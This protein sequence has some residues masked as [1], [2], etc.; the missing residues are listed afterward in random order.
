MVKK[1]FYVV[2]ITAA[3]VGIVALIWWFFNRDTTPAQTGS[4][5]F[6]SG[7]DAPQSGNAV[8]GTPT[9]VALPIE[10]QNVGQGG[11][12]SS[13]SIPAGT[14]TVRT[15]TLARGSYTLAPAESFGTYTV[16]SV[17]GG[18]L[19]AGQYTFAAPNLTTT[20]GVML[21][22]MGTSSN[23]YTITPGQI[24]SNIVDGIVGTS[25]N[26][27]NI[28]VPGVTWLSGTTT[29]NGTTGNN[30]GTVF[31]PTG[32]NQLNNDT[33]SGGVL[34]NISGGGGGTG[35]QGGLGLG[36][37]LVGAAVAG[38]LSCG[39]AEALA[40]AGKALGIT[41]ST[42]LGAPG[43]ALTVG[44][45]GIELGLTPI[46]VSTVNNG[47]TTV[48]T[49]TNA[50]LGAILIKLGGAH[51]EQ[52]V[53]NTINTF[54]SCLARTV[55][56]IALNQIT[57]SVV[58]WINSGFGADGGPGSGGPSFVTNPERFFTNLAD[59]TAGEFIKGSSLSFLCSPFQ[60]QIRI[61]IA[62]SYAQRNAYSC[63][64]TGVTNNI[65]NFMN[66]SFSAG[67]WPAMLS[68]TTMPTNNPYGAFMYAEA[69]LSYSVQTAQGEQRRQLDLGRGLF[70]F[71]QKKGC[72]N[73]PIR[74]DAS[75]NRSVTEIGDP[76]GGTS[77]EVCEIVN[78]TPGSVIAD[79]IGATESST[80]DQLS[81]AKSFDEIISALIAQLMTRTLQGGLLNLSGQDGYASNFYS[82]EE[83]AA[84]REAQDFLGE[85]QTD[86]NTAQNLGVI[87]QGSIQDI[88]STQRRLSELG[89]CWLGAN[90]AGAAENAAA[91]SSTVAMLET[92]VA[93]YNDQIVRINET[94]TALV[95]FQSRTLSAGSLSDLE[96]VRR[97]HSAAAAQGRLVSSADITTAQQDRATL[98]SQMAT[99]NQQ[100][101]A[102]LTQCNAFR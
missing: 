57:N 25:T 71:K 26:T 63:T 70:E 18:R 29:N 1:I 15:G 34:P 47:Q 87:K 95:E 78:A 76:E 64:L 17:N 101:T 30:A 49:G 69:G 61:A 37:A 102:G 96:A 100:T 89:N 81:L 50:L 2:L 21:S 44:G 38:G 86:S 62:K 51:G 22:P 48:L 24:R 7:Q 72:I 32:I 58:N 88:Q 43:V 31:N 16:T 73:T 82:T 59:K 97:D 74:E 28:G 67:G 3:V 40:W 36:G 4:G 27:G 10:G 19:E 75:A 41:E 68:F 99:I 52:K 90:V 42:T 5:T 45:E 94:I 12:G 23:V 66:G 6:G 91:A 39:A 93:F 54:W 14:Y 56:R 92:R 60:L 83:L 13:Q 33:P 80:L 20:Y 77:Y 79:A 35:S 55:A 84:Q 8:G 11:L 46:S 85:L 9:N 53:D 65:R 98:Q